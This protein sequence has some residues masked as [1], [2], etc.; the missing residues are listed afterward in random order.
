MRMRRLICAAAMGAVL[1]GGPPATAQSADPTVVAGVTVLARRPHVVAGL[2]ITPGRRCLGARHPAD[3]E[4]PAPKLVSTFPAK[5]GVVRPGILV[6]RLTFDLPMTCEGLLDGHPDLLNPCPQP[7][8]DPL[9]SFDRRTFLTVC[10]V[11]KS[12]HYGLWLNHSIYHRFTGL[13]GRSSQASELVFDTSDG[14]ETTTVEQAIAEDNWL[15]RAALPQQPP[16][17]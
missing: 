3:P 7:L 9:L 17:D 13:A 14:P 1:T 11:K 12:S 2:T 6:L 15:Q 10:Q 5:G 4:V 16:K 8:H